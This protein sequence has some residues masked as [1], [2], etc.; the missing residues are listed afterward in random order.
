MLA[1]SFPRKLLLRSLTPLLLCDA[2]GV[3][4]FSQFAF[5]KPGLFFWLSLRAPEWTTI[6]IQHHTVA[7]RRRVVENKIG[8]TKMRSSYCEKIFEQRLIH[9]AHI[10]SLLFQVSGCL[11][12]R[13]RSSFALF[14]VSS[15]LRLCSL[16]QN[17]TDWEFINVSSIRESRFIT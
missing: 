14:H 6:R 15:I 12:S 7:N 1:I 17:S 10:F 16:F 11:V 13:Y 4:G 8:V 2:S 9:C 5:R 3:S